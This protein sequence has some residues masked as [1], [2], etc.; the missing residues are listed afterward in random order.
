MRKSRMGDRLGALEPNEAA[1]LKE[2]SSVA[3]CRH[4]GVVGDDADG[5]TLLLGEGQ[6]EAEGITG[7]CLIEGGRR[8]VRQHEAG[9]AERRPGYCC[10]LQLTDRH[11]GGMPRAQAIDAQ[12]S[13]ELLDG[14]GVVN[15]S[16]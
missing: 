13:K 5:C 11:L 8:L 2:Q 14:I 1:L 3:Q 7:S 10:A 15:G 4:G 9:A 16:S 12:P 6:E